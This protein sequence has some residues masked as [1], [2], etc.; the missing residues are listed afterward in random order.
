MQQ[1]PFKLGVFM[2]VGN[3]G[4]IISRNSPQ[5]MP[6]FEL[7]KRIALLAEEIGFDYV[8][9]MA[10]WSGYGGEVRFW[11]FSVESFTMMTALA[12]VTERLQL[13]ASVAPILIHPAILAKIAVTLDHI[14]NGR[15][16]INV[17]SSDHEF[18]HMGLY[19]ENFEDFRHEYI[20][21]WLRVCKQLWTGE[22]VYFEGK[23]FNLTG[24]ASNPTPVQ[25]PWPTIIYATSSEGGF[26]F[27]AEHCD[28]A[29]VRADEQRNNAS[30][31][32]K[33]FAADGGRIIKT[34][35]HVCLIQGETD[36]DAQ[37]ILRHFGEGAALE[38]IFNVYERSNREFQGDKAARGREMLEQRWPRP[39]FYHAF[40]LIGGPDTIADF[41]E[42]MARNGDFDGMLFSFPDYIEGLT[43]FNRHVVPRLKERGLR[44]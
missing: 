2:P 17:V 27:V 40:P 38:S 36:E 1:Q 37:R 31:Q 32:L 3:N 5:Y 21:E 13:V 44:V 30:K 24:Y 8:F 20:D 28:E 9:S 34:Q 19:P 42:D 39:L 15:L 43:Q 18:I 16:A 4:W 26:K 23:W 25:Q 35:A 11:D 10:K 29:F 41:A 33:K 12:A 6:T 22:P 7:N 14:S